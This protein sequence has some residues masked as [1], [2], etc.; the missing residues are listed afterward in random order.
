LSAAR[1]WVLFAVTL[2]LLL[3]A[4]ALLVSVALRRIEG[5]VAETVPGESLYREVMERVGREHVDPVD[6]ERAVYGAMKGLVSELDPHSRVYD[7]VEWAEF[8]RESRGETIGIGIEIVEAGPDLAIASVAP[9]SPAAIAGIRAGDRLIAAGGRRTADDRAAVLR[10]LAGARGTRIELGVAAAGRAEER[11][12][13]VARD[14]YD[15]ETVH[16]RMLAGPVVYV[17]VEAFRP[18]TAEAFDRAVRAAL[19]AEPGRKGLVVDLRFNRGG[20]FDSAVAM[21][22]AWLAGGPIGR[23]SGPTQDETPRATPD[24]PFATVPTVVLVNGSTASAAEVVAGALQDA[25]AAM[26]VG[27]RTFGKGVVQEIIEFDSWPGGMKLTT[28]RT[29]T[30][31]GRCVDRGLGGASGPGGLLPD[32]VVALSD[33]EDAGLEKALDQESWPAWIRARLAPEGSSMQPSDPQLAAALELLEGRPADTLVAVRGD[34]RG[35]TSR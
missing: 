28:A 35:T 25:Q 20:S 22:D 32:F 34:G 14:T 17:R 27:E 4:T 3:G 2:A 19:A 16:V 12:V 31:S 30:P 11:R 6:S 21:A 26:L 23:T 7:P 8:Q 29:F 33:S 10:A 9:G 18:R 13:E 5:L 24:A 15:V 1:S